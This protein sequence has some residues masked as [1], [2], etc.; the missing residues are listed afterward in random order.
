MIADKLDYN[1][2]KMEVVQLSNDTYYNLAFGEQCLDEDN[3]DE[4]KEFKEQFPYGFKLSKEVEFVENSDLIECK[5]I[6][7][8]ECSTLFTHY[9][10]EGHWFK[11]EFYYS[12]DKKQAYYRTYDMY[13]RRFIDYGW[14]DVHINEYGKPEIRPKGCIFPLQGKS[15]NRY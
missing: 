8:C 4:I 10:L 13:N 15:W 12:E 5:V 14:N 9:R 11:S 2:E 1:P 3:L 6:P 7:I